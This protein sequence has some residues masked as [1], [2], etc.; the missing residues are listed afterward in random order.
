MQMDTASLEFGRTGSEPSL[1]F[2]NPQDVN[3]DGLLD[4]VCHFSAQKAAFKL[5]DAR[6]VL[7]G[8]TL[9]GASITGADSLVVV[10]P[11]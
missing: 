9:G 3:N 10:P 7:T 4:L 6:G 8:E 11:S 5:G 2:C 1:A